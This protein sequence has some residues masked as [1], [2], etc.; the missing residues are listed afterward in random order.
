MCDCTACYCGPRCGLTGRSGALHSHPP[1]GSTIL[2]RRQLRHRVPW[3]TSASR[4]RMTGRRH[5]TPRL[6]QMALRLAD[7]KLMSWHR[8]HRWPPST[9]SDRGCWTSGRQCCDCLSMMTCGKNLN[10]YG[11]Y[12]T[13]VF[14]CIVLR[15]S[16]YLFIY[17]DLNMSINCRN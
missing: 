9:T 13:L 14:V 3:S 2:G 11:W 17:C 8:R 1:R 15:K 10:S 7:C 4:R 5:S 12:L 6:L 16:Y